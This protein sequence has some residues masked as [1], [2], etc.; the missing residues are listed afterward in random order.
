MSEHDQTTPP[1]DD[2]RSGEQPLNETIDSNVDSDKNDEVVQTVGWSMSAMVIFLGIIGFVIGLDSRG[3]GPILICGFSALLI[4]GGFILNQ[5]GN[6]KT[7]KPKWRMRFSIRTMLIVVTLISVVLGGTRL[8]VL[9][10]TKYQVEAYLFVDEDF[11][12][13]LETAEDWYEHVVEHAE[14]FGYEFVDQGPDPRLYEWQSADSR[15]TSN[16]DIT[17]GPF[18]VFGNP[19]RKGASYSVSANYFTIDKKQAELMEQVKAVVDGNPN[20]KFPKLK[21]VLVRLDSFSKTTIVEGD[22]RKL[23]AP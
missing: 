5:L 4:V 7:F 19:M 14:I 6:S 12:K 16:T 13:N 21:I 20:L 2:D 23:E 18:F 1:S 10:N 15:S 9:C 22:P 3:I 11:E 8:W 17:Y